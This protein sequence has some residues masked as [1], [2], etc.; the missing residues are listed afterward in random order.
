MERIA[1]PLF[2]LPR[3]KI[4]LEVPIVFLASQNVLSLLQLEAILTSFLE[5]GELLSQFLV[6]SLQ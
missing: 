4:L 6:I 5:I 2:D 1:F 3:C